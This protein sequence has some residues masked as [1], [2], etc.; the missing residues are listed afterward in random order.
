MFKSVEIMSLCVI[1]KNTYT[2]QITTGAWFN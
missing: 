2:S 1:A